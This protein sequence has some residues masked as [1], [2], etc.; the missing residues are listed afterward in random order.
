[1]LSYII[2]FP[3][4]AQ[5]H[6]H[7]FINKKFLK[8]TYTHAHSRERISLNML[9]FLRPKHIF[10]V[11]SLFLRFTHRIFIAA[12]TYGGFYRTKNFGFSF[13]LSFNI[14]CRR[15]YWRMSEYTTRKCHHIVIMWTTLTRVSEARMEFSY[16]PSGIHL[17][18]KSESD[19]GQK[20]LKMSNHKVLTPC[21]MKIKR[22][23]IL[24]NMLIRPMKYS[25]LKNKS[26]NKKVAIQKKSKRHK[27]EVA[28]RDSFIL[29][30]F[31]LPRSLAFCS[32]MPFKNIK[33]CVQTAIGR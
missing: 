33:F 1:M 10:I 5:R 2:I 13:R 28:F 32:T 8:A 15:S 19:C 23:S 25:T 11:P 6:Q 21:S 31:G 16:S 30:C 26:M 4:A 24:H 20:L 14:F 22:I 18:P 17:R 12:A 9:I 7:F 27:I 29:F 3:H